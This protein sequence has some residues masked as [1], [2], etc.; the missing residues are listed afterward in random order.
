[1]GFLPQSP[2]PLPAVPAT[3]SGG[4][5]EFFGLVSRGAAL[6]L[7]TLGFY[8]FWLATD[9]RRHLWV[10]T[11]VDGD[12]AEYTGRGKELLIGFLFAMAILVPIYFAYFIISVEAERF[13]GFASIPLLVAFY[14]FGQFAIYRARRYRLTRTVWR[15]VRFWMDGSGWAYAGRAMLWA[16]LVVLT[17]GLAW[18]WREAALERYKMQH[19]HYGDLQGDFEGNAWDFFKRAWWLWLLAPFAIVLFPLF[20]F[21]YAQ[22]KA[23]EWR[24]WLS[25]LRFG[26]VRLESTLSS[27]VLHKLYWKVIGWFFLLSIA[28]GL[29]FGG[30]FALAKEFIGDELEGP[31]AAEALFGNIPVLVALGLGY[32]ALI[33]SLNVVMRL[34][35]LR[36][37]WATLLVSVQLH[38]LEAVA[39]VNAKGELASALGE[40]FADGLDVAG[41]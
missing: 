30:V 5:G 38:G 3:F 8:R 40:G 22:F 4:R 11:A 35:L 13:K 23:I 9:I 15:G 16:L 32:V 7:V 27:G 29:Y 25:G 37:I 31:A 36:D 34:Y 19:S 24:W 26:G 17:L 41:F 12:A 20:P 10:N 28:S 18:P 39:D 14:A 21:V 33:L 1:M 2:P 6:E